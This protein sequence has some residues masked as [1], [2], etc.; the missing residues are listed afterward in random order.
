MS[1]HY[2]IHIE[3]GNINDDREIEITEAIEEIW[4]GADEDLSL[5]DKT[6]SSTSEGSLT[7]GESEEEFATRLTRAI[8]EANGGFCYVSVAMTC[9]EYLPTEYY[10][11]DEDDYKKMTV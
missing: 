10:E 2:R 5:Y 6:Y 1:R 7:G 4:P 9:L 3:F 8:W 11:F